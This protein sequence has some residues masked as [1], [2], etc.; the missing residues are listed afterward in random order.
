MAEQGWYDAGEVKPRDIPPNPRCP[1]CQTG[2]MFR[3]AAA[4]PATSDDH[5]ERVHA[6]AARAEAASDV[7]R[8]QF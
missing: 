7:V 8:D 6:T 3:G 2:G 1:D 5:W 4:V